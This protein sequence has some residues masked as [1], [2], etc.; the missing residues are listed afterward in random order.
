MK[1]KEKIALVTGSSRGIGRAI[2]LEFAREGANVVVNSSKTETE[3]K[4]VVEE[5]KN[6]GSDAI[7]IKCDISKEEQV[8]EMINKTL[9]KFGKIDILVNNAGIVY[10]VP[11]FQKTLDQWKETFGVNLFGVFLCSKNV[12]EHMKK[13]NS[14]NIINISSNNGIGVTSPESADYDA[15]KAGIIGFTKSLAE[16]LAPY[17]IRV[18]AIAPGWI[19]TEMNKDLPEDFIQEEKNKTFMKRFGKPEEIAKVALFLASD[20]AS[21]VTGSNFVVDGG[22]K[23]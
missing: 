8:K 22:Y 7:Y 13:N 21:F 6:I 14:G 9:E 18:N 19:D 1:F 23:I 10:D 11:L 2:A 15:T 3:G 4:K 20:E 5:I 12:S 17:N 16:E